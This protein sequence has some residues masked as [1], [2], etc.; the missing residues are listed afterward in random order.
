VTRFFLRRLAAAAALLVAVVS[1]AFLVVHALPGGPGVIPEDPRVPPSQAQRLRAAWGLDRPL[2]ER[3]VRFLFAA[4]RG[5]WGP[6]LA[7]HRPAAQVVGEALPWTLL[8]DGTALAIELGGGLALGLLAARRAGGH[9]D[10]LLR[11]S[12]LALRA[13][14]GFW[15]ALLLLGTFAVRWPLLP[16]GGVTSPGLAGGAWTGLRDLV[17]HLALPALAVGLPAAASAARF[18]RAALL[19][20][21]SE[22]FLVAARARGLGRARVLFAHSL[23]AAAAPLLQLVGFSCGALLSGSL[24]VEVV[25]AWPG[26]GR[27][28][29]DAL[30]AR[31][32]PVLVA[33]AALAAAAVIA[34]SAAAE[35]AHAALDPRV[36]DA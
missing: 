17:A 11:G 30:A 13:V 8:L 12:T 25:F 22:P 19:E 21:A 35:L 14:P 15:L 36:R 23:R 33:G 6:S 16:A 34:G 2:P 26:L 3:Y 9:L 10:R 29:Y 32:Y 20:I 7:Q 1:G 27:V 5:D 28:T 31:D 18:V 24:A 4:A